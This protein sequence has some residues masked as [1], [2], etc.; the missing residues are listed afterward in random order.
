MRLHSQ[1][2]EL[3][4]S[5][6]LCGALC[7]GPPQLKSAAPERLKPAAGLKAQLAW[8]RPHITVGHPGLQ[9]SSLLLPNTSCQS[10]AEAG[11]KL[12]IWIEW[13]GESSPSKGYFT[14]AI[15]R[16]PAHSTG[17][18]GPMAL[19]SQGIAVQSAGRYACKPGRVQSTLP[20][21]SFV[22]FRPLNNLGKPQG[23]VALPSCLQKLSTC[24]QEKMTFSSLHTKE[25]LET[26][27]CL[28]PSAGRLYLFLSDQGCLLS[29][30]N[31]QCKH[32]VL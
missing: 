24:Q 9:R 17:M 16:E 27:L 23:G 13:E 25:G 8:P 22:S 26:R 28:R 4:D 11:L 29:K 10:T 31:V 12:N 21:A 3:R 1:L 14:Q 18:L 20:P 30:D 19:E 7:P 5:P 32:T 15:G 6:R 2:T